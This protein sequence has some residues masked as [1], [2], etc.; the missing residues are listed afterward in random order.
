MKLA[1]VGVE[2]LSYGM[3][4]RGKHHARF[5]DPDVPHHIISRVTQG[6]HLLRPHRDLNS[7]IAGLVGR[8]QQRWSQVRLY[9]MAF[10]SNHAHFM[11][12]GPAHEVAAFLGFIKREIARRWGHRLDI[13]WRGGF[14]EE[15]KAAALPTA[16]SQVECLKYILSQG[17]KEGLVAHP[18]QWPGI[19]CVRALL[20]GEAMTGL[21]LNGTSYSRAIDAERGKRSPSPVF[22]RDHSVRYVVAF[23]SIPAWDDLSAD[24][25]QRELSRLVDE[26]VAEGATLRCGRPPLGKKAIFRTP[27]HRRSELPVVPWLQRRRVI[28][29]WSDPQALETIEYRA[30]YRRFQHD[31]REAASVEG[32]KRGARYPAGAFIAGQWA[33]RDDAIPAAA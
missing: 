15:Y 10:L 31:Y 18:E 8:A 1:A 5:I 7:I 27:L 26:I 32:R 33:H 30:R 14:W 22:K 2:L 12:Q 19:N 4:F 23:A 25:R 16:S 13:N 28:V 3:T 29:C 21:F 9:A 11:L 20:R 6:M 17:V 24:A